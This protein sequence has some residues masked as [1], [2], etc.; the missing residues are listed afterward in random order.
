[1]CEVVAPCLVI[2]SCTSYHTTVVV[3]VVSI[4]RFALYADVERAGCVSLMLFLV[5]NTL[6]LCRSPEHC[7][8]FPRVHSE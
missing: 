7:S 4:F 8:F 3:V 2:T 1:M 6:N 5:L